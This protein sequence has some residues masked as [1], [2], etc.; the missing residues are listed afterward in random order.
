MIVVFFSV[1]INPLDQTEYKS[2]PRKETSL[3][4]KAEKEV[5]VDF[6]LSIQEKSVYC[7][8]PPIRKINHP[9][10]RSIKAE[11]TLRTPSYFTRGIRISAWQTVLENKRVPKILPVQRSKNNDKL[12]FLSKVLYHL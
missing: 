8:P 6:F 1:A 11:S 9:P 7:P 2:P 4:I 3:H 10:R 12:S 5:T